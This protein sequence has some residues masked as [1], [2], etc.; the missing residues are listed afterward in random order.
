MGSLGSWGQGPALHTLQWVQGIPQGLG[1]GPR[2]CHPAALSLRC[3]GSVVSLG[4]GWG[5]QGGGR[6]AGSLPCLGE[7]SLTVLER[8]DIVDHCRHLFAWDTGIPVGQWR[9]CG[10]GVGP[11]LQLQS[12]HLN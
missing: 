11:R 3:P 5:G 7:L 1:L 2:K 4:Q 12:S 10:F 9:R 8:K 6:G